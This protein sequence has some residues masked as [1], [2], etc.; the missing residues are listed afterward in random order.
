MTEPGSRW[1]QFIEELKQRRV[2]RAVVVYAVAGWIL[3][4]IAATVFPI[5]EFPDWTLK[6]TVIVVLAGFPLVLVAAW[7]LERKQAATPKSVSLLTR[8][9]LV[10]L[11]G[12]LG[13]S[14]YHVFRS[15]DAKT[16][17][18][19]NAVAVLPFEVSGD[20]S[21]AYLREG[22]V[23]LLAANLDGADE[24]WSVDPKN[25]IDGAKR[26]VRDP[27]ALAAQ[28]GAGYFV[29]GQVVQV[30][31]NLRI[32][33]R[34]QKIADGKAITTAAADGPVTDVLNVIDQVAAQLLVGRSA[35]HKGGTAEVTTQSLAALKAY[36]AGQD[37]YTRLDF[38]EALKRFEEALHEDSTFAQ[39]HVGTTWASWWLGA[40]TAPGLAA[41]KRHSAKLSQRE[42]ELLAAHEAFFS[43]DHYEAER[44]YRAILV[45]YPN[46]LAALHALSEIMVH[47][48][49]L[50]GQSYVINARDDL[51]RVLSHLPT[52]GEALFH[53]LHLAVQAGDR[54]HFDSLSA[55]AIALSGESAEITSIRLLRAFVHTDSSA[56]YERKRLIAPLAAADDWP[57]L[58]SAGIIG[59]FGKNYQ[60][61][62][63]IFGY[64]TQPSRPKEVQAAGHIMRA[65]ISGGSG[66][67]GRANAE[68]SAV[69][70]LDPSAIALYKNSLLL[71]PFRSQSTK[72]RQV[73]REQIQRWNPD[74]DLGVP[75]GGI[76]VFMYRPGAGHEAG[77]SYLLGLLDA[78]D[79]RYNAALRHATALEQMKPIEGTLFADLGKAVRA[80]VAR[81][82][83]DLAGALAALELMQNKS[84]FNHLYVSPLHL[85]S[86]ERFLHGILLEHFGRDEEAVNWFRSLTDRIALTF[87]EPYVVP[88]AFRLASIYER[89]GER[90]PAI[91]MYQQVVDLWREAD[92]EF[93]P[94]VQQ[95]ERRLAALS[96]E[97][98][99]N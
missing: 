36:L 81:L 83:G 11:A 21:I 24:L 1:P 71:V 62:R 4:Q 67:F 5:L 7:L 60:V 38:K 89:R 99:R 15:R 64:L 41:A 16:D 97:Q 33:A 28:L 49:F 74:A 85:R 65:Y 90:E 61:A 88:A 17:P 52:H 63:D 82:R 29:T 35:A 37:A 26:A 27:R 39:A 73:A 18:V 10:I 91:K 66:Q 59:S 45:S 94:T 78:Q 70:R 23:M 86:R 92:A 98:P 50:R 93:R 14:G 40:P 32:S 58:A 46:E 34:L 76:P 42:K 6:L 80:E 12:L 47:W 54:A 48:S 19:S 69:D 31:Q 68:L 3:I 56:H 13:F 72:E 8:V 96:A 87:D 30:G 55:K 43:G 25:V 84:G 75:A 44:R 51:D 20:Q 95:A 57:I 22:M 77:R 2:V 53:S 9:A 79:G